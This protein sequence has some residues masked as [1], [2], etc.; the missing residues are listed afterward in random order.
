VR[1]YL[2]IVAVWLALTGFSAVVGFLIINPMQD[3]DLSRRGV[4][5]RGVVTILEP[6]NHEIVRYRYAVS[7]RDYEGSGHGGRGNAAFSNMTIGQ[8]VIVFYDP[9]KPEISTL[10]YPERHLTVNLAG[11]V[12]VAIAIP[13]VVVWTLARRGILRYR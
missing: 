5:T 13:L 4:K 6:K 7:G 2:L 11:V 3:F 9:T 8:D 10:G 1:K 12:F